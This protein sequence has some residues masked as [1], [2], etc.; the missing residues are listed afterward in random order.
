MCI[1]DRVVAAFLLTNK[2][3]SPQ[4]SLWLVPLAVLAVPRWRWL[5]SWMVVDAAMWA[6]RMYYYLGTGNKGLP[7]G[8]FLGAVLVRDLLVVALCALVVHEVLHPAADRVR[9]SLGPAGSHEAAAVDDP[10]GGFLD[11]APDRVVLPWPRGAAR[12][13]GGWLRTVGP[14]V[15]RGERAS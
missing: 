14:G 10:S 7:E 1:R 13:I 6:P 9:R 15:Q 4:Y 11:D 8:W 5:L 12:R 2:V 3:W